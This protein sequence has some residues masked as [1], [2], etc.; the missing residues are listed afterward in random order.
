[1]RIGVL[2]FQGDVREHVDYFK[3]AGAVAFP[4]ASL[5]DLKK[6]DALSIPGGES[7]TISKFVFKEGFHEAIKEFVAEGKAVFATCA[8]LILLSKEIVGNSVDSLGLLDISVL[9]NA[10]GR[11]KDSFEADLTL[12]FDPARPL[13]G[14]F[15]R[16]P[17]IS[18]VGSSVEVVA[19]LD[20]EPVMVRQGRMLAATF[21]PELTDDLR[22][23]KY[24]IE[25]VCR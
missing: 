3:K 8:G 13:R 19:E 15:I 22:V 24:F 4:V 9:R 11:Q 25:S 10:Y 20:G 16:A 23:A 1:M 2:R 5:E 17:R 7:T 18:R 21:H 6:A 14:V 12:S